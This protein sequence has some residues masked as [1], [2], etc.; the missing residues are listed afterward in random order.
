MIV[1]T[2]NNVWI[3]ILI[4]VFR[5]T[6]NVDV[7]LGHRLFETSNILEIKTNIHLCNVINKGCEIT[8]HLEFDIKSV[9]VFFN[10]HTTY[11]RLLSIP[12]E[13]PTLFTSSLYVCLFVSL[14]MD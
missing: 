1:L 4:F 11:L 5:K 8:F 14:F 10:T 7:A 2:R 6:C 3:A 12:S 13:L 9:C